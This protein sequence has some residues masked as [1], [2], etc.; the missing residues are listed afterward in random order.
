V[1]SSIRLA[2]AQ[3]PQEHDAAMRTLTGCIIGGILIAIGPEIAKWITGLKE[4]DL[5]SDYSGLKAGKY[6]YTGDTINSD[7]EL[8]RAVQEGRCLPS[9]TGTVIY[10]VINLLRIVGGLVVLVGLIWGGISLRAGRA[11]VRRFR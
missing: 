6:Y 8:L 7:A 9:G 11:T 4:Y 10:T 1:Y 2:R 5:R 3:T